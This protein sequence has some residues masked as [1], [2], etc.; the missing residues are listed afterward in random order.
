MFSDI[1]YVWTTPTAELVLKTLGA[2]LVI[3]SLVGISRF[4]LAQLY[5]SQ[6]ARYN[7]PKTKGTACW[8]LVT[9]ASDGLGK[10][11]S[12][13]LLKR[14]WN[15]LLHGRNDAKL[16]AVK[17][18]LL[19]RHPGRKV[20]TVVADAGIYSSQSH[21]AV[22]DKVQSLPQNE[23]LT[24]LINNVG[25]MPFKPQYAPLC[26]TTHENI[27][28]CINVN[29]RFM[30]HLI[31]ALLPI[32]RDNSPS[33]IANCGSIGGKIPPPYL[34]AYAATKAYVHTL[35][36]GLK[37]ELAAEGEKWKD[38]DVIAF[39]IGNTLTAGKSMM[40]NQMVTPSKMQ[41]GWLADSD[42]QGTSEIY[43]S[44]PRQRPAHAA[45]STT[46]VPA[47]KRLSPAI[48]Q[49]GWLRR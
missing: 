26:S 28:V 40:R 29:L 44:A 9:G 33:L 4:L 30:T 48:G 6:L 14:G 1:Y 47:T 13:E 34:A 15:V 46:S 12:D 27:D 31:A 3:K 42:G 8:A 21:V 41:N 45:A 32:L 20:D 39:V 16:E 25:G 5:G 22:V 43:L 11:Y 35:T 18:E 49:H 37:S 10:A 24:L 19:E 17:H 36:Q 2:L 23:P 7:H 38:V